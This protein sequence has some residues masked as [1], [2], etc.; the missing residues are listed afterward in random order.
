[1]SEE[2]EQNIEKR[3]GSLVPLVKSL[4]GGAFAI[5]GAVVACGVWVYSQQ[6]ANAKQEVRLDKIEPRVSQLE[7]WKLVRDSSPIVTLTDMHNLDKRLQKNEDQL[8]T[9]K[10]QNALILQELRNI[11]GKP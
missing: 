5:A 3:L 2:G 8:S 1:M 9:I 4:I 7:N 11:Q 10:E 6:E